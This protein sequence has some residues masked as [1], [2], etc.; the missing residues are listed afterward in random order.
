MAKILTSVASVGNVLKHEY[1]PHTGYCRAKGTYTKTADFKVGM[2][3]TLTGG[4][5]V[6]FKDANAANPI[7]IVVDERVYDAAL[8]D[9][10]NTAVIVRGPAVVRQGGLSVSSTGAT[11]S[12]AVAALEAAGIQVADAF[13]TD[14]L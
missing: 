6:D 11:L 4:K 2:I 1:A 3:V 7:A 12:T 9:V 8:G 10:A 13:S 14:E 5:Y